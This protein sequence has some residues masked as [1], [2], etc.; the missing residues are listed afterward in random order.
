MDGAPFVSAI[1]GEGVK[2]VTALGYPSSPAFARA[3]S[4]MG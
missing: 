1:V 2:V 3:G 4:I